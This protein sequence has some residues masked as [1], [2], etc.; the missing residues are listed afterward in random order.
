MFYGLWRRRAKYTETNIGLSYEQIGLWDKAQQLYEVAQVKAR[1]GA[2]PYSQSEYALWE[3]NWIQCAE[4]LQHWDVLTELAKHE[5]FTDLLLECGWRVADWNSDRDALEQSVKSVMDVPTPRRQMFKTFLALQ[6]FAESRKGDQEVRKLCDEG[7]QLSL[8]K[9]VS[10]PIRYTPAHK[11]LLHGFQQYMEFLEATQ[12]YANL[13]TTTVQNL[14]SKA[15]E[16]KR[17]LQAWRD[18]LPNT[19]DDVN[20]WND[21]V[22]WRQHAFQVINNAYLPLIP[23]LQQSNSNS[24]INTHAYRGYHEIAWVINRFAHVARKHNMPDVCISQLARI[25]TLPNIEIQEAFLKLREQAKCHYQNMNELTTGLDVI[26]NTNLV[27]FG[28]VQKAE[29]FT[30]KGMFLSKLRAYEEANQ[31]FATAVQIDLNL[32]KAWAQWG[33]FN[34]RR[35][36]EEPNNISFASNAISCY[37]Q[38]AGLYKNS[39]IRELLCRILWLISIDDASGML[40]NAFDS[41]RGEIPVWYWITFIP[42][43]LTSLS[44]KEANMVRH[45]LIRIA[46]SYP[47]ALHFQLRTTKEDF[48]VIQRQ[49][50]AVMGDKPDTND[51][52]GRRQPWE[53]LQELNNILKTAYPLLALSLESL[54]AQINDRFKS[55]TDEDLFRL[56]NVLLIDGTLNYNRL[57]FPRKIQNFLKIQKKFGQIFYNFVGALYKTKVQCRLY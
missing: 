36:S 54:V 27:Y 55:T 24:N 19:W 1:S 51:R 25:Y 12:I 47:Q 34:D 18:R 30:L 37:L 3:D 6:N 16:I 32:A 46:K 9:W 45:I 44:H 5:G 4:K 49:T 39:K 20:M 13:H 10:L 57:P 48:A 8:I 33:F 28:T 17:I 40:T 22:T 43:L 23:A 7:I 41:F 53:Y 14:D 52:N 15:Q 31:A 38:A 26:S 42:Q 21:L 35:L 11:W 29:F 56:I 50:M 2:L